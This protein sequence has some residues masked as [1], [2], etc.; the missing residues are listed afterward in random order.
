MEKDPSLTSNPEYTG[1]NES[2][3]DKKIDQIKDQNL[4][5]TILFSSKPLKKKKPFN[6]IRVRSFF[7]MHKKFKRMIEFSVH[8]SGIHILHQAMF[9]SDNGCK[10][11]RV[12]VEKNLF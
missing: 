11:C 4:Q 7:I 2:K 12:Y 8:P 5:G 1:F 6:W 3:L 10:M 9:H